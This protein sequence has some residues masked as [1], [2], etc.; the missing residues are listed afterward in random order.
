MSLATPR[1][2]SFSERSPVRTDLSPPPTT[3]SRDLYRPLLPC[4]QVLNPPSGPT[5]AGQAASNFEKLT[6]SARNNVTLACNEC[7]VK[8]AR[9]DGK[10]PCTRCT[11]KGLHCLFESNRDRRRV[12][13]TPAETL[14]LRE[15]ISQY[16]RLF[17]IMHET[18]AKEAVQ[19]LH[20][21]RS[22]S[23]DIQQSPG[24]ASG[25]FPLDELLQL[26]EQFNQGSG[27]PD[28]IYGMKTPTSSPN[29]ID[30]AHLS[31]LNMRSS[32]ARSLGTSSTSP[33]EHHL[34]NS[35]VCSFTCTPSFFFPGCYAM[36]I[37]ELF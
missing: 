4:P 14:I 13:G 3:Q 15:K 34:H 6:R 11:L 20:L 28:S 9:C 21:L 7:K 33:I 31:R 36:L 8:K 12:R 26:V 2:S 5:L 30:I 1:E 18:S 35:T 29:S 25:D 37:H 22:C 17:T 16:Q 32:N 10:D 24:N 23:N 19:I 27:S